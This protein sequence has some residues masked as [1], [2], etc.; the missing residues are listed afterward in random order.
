MESMDKITLELLTNKQQYNKYLSKNDPMK[1]KEHEEY[2][3]KIRKN[4]YKIL[5]LS[6]QFLENPKMSFNIEMNE[7]FNIFAKTSIK[8]LEM[9]ELETENLYNFGEN[10]QEDEEG[11]FINIEESDTPYEIS[12]FPLDENLKPTIQMNSFWGDNIKKTE[13]IIPKCT[14]DM[15]KKNHKSR[16]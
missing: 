14:I 12:N 1:F 15:F 4:K 13:A 5:N 10:D 11:L 6:R 7:M 2:L 3:E 16:K 9:R 8:Y